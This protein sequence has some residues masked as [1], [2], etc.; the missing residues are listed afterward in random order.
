MTGD[1]IESDVEEIIATRL[2]VDQGEFDDATSFG[3]DGLNADSLDIVE[4]AE[5][6]DENL[7]VHIPDDDLEDLETVGDVKEYVQTEMTA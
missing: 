7:G 5:A 4:M 1:D 3:S 2:R 6:L